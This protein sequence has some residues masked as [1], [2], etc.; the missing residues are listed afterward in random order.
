MRVLLKL[1]LDAAPD[2]VWRGIR[3][4]EL[5]RAVSAPLLAIRSREPGGFPDEWSGNGPHRVTIR[6]LGVLPMGEQTIDAHFQ[7][8]PDVRVMHD[9]GRPLSG[10]LAL[11]SHW[12]HTMAVSDAGG[13]RTL[14]RD[15]LM[16]RAGPLTPLLW[17]GFWVFWQWRALQ[18]RRRVA[19]LR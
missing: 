11:I 5:F 18:L 19:R 14:F 8:R 15:R 6:A 17:P 10:A 1:E 4:P 2:A 3:S 7:E 9:T 12:D 16:F 13:G